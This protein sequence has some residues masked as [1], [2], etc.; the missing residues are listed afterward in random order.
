MLYVDA[1]NTAAVAAL[2][3]A[4]TSP[5]GHADV[6]YRVPIALTRDRKLTASGV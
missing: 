3:A 1:D 6:M 2:R 4:R 5:L